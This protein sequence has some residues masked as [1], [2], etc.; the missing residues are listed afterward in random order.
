MGV[1]TT[2]ARKGVTLLL[3]YLTFTKVRPFVLFP[4]CFLFFF[5]AH[6]SSSVFVCSLLILCWQNVCLH[7]RSEPPTPPEWSF[8]SVA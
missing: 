3:S 2:T 4:M 1:V 5:F 7:S 6:C 8:S